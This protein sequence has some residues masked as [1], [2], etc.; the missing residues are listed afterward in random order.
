MHVI[1]C[2]AL[3]FIGLFI[4]SSSSLAQKGFSIEGGLLYDLPAGPHNRPYPQMKGGV[5]FT[6]NFGYDFF[7]RAGIL[8]GVLHSSHV[9]QLG[10]R[11]GVILEQSADRTTFFLKA[12]ALPLKRDKFEIVVA[13][14]I[15]FF[16]I[17]GSRVLQPNEVSDEFFGFEDDFSGLGF[18]GNFDFRYYITKGL[19]VSIYLGGDVVNYSRYELLGIRTNYGRKLPGGDSFNWGLTLYH[20]IGVPNL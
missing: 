16:D 20:H 3:A 19:A 4:L 5:G 9:Y 13:A 10:I 11:N 8:M 14:G 12:R 6:A 7:E 2:L 17:T 15:G 1:R 18:I